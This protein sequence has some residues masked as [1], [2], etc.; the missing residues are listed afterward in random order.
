M[1]MRDKRPCFR[2][3]GGCVWNC[4]ELLIWCDRE[5]A[6]FVTV[7]LTFARMRLLDPYCVFRPCFVGRLDSTSNA[8]WVSGR[9]IQASNTQVLR[10]DEKR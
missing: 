9:L 10:P 8:Y 5:P 7:V 1:Y 4:D 3:F 6:S 2:H